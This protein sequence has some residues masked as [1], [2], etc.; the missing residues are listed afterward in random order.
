LAACVHGRGG[1]GEQ[2]AVRRR[3]ARKSRSN[4]VL[5]IRKL[6]IGGI[7]ANIFR[8]IETPCPN[9]AEF[10]VQFCEEI[11]RRNPNHL[12]ALVLQGDAY[13]R[14]GQY[15]KGLELDLKLTQIRPDSELLR[16]NLACSYALAGQKDTAFRTLHQAVALGYHDVEH[17][18]RDNDLNS[19]KSDP[20]FEA[21]VRKL[22]AEETQP[23]RSS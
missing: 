17:L 12:E 2:I 3:S 11:L 15:Q 22:I 1:G 8:P 16:Y 5:D 19:L 23:A 9:D 13:S 6:Y 14:Q 21:L 18:C 10:E 4:F 20:R 7:T